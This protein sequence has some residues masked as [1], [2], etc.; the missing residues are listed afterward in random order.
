M[1][2]KDEIL[3][4]RYIDGSLDDTELDRFTRRLNDEPELQSAVRQIQQL[5]QRL[6]SI[7]WQHPA[8]GF[9]QRVIDQL[10][11]K[12]TVIRSIGVDQQSRWI[13]GY[14]VACL[15]AVVV[16]V[17][18]ISGIEPETSNSIWNASAARMTDLAMSPLMQTVSLVSVAIFFL[19][20]T[21]RWLQM[22]YQ[23]KLAKPV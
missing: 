6:S 10:P 23:G 11:V 9:A 15:M 8:E 19:F 22:R 17:L 3:I 14:L 21:D 13:K 4:W 2:E 16:T 7:Q 20:I 12:K 1:N 5:D 18:V